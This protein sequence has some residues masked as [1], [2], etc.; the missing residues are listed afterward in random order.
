MKQYLANF[1]ELNLLGAN[2]VSEYLSGTKTNSQIAMDVKNLFIYAYNQGIRSTF[3]DLDEVDMAMYDDYVT[4]L[5]EKANKEVYKR[6]DGKDFDSKIKGYLQDG[7]ADGIQKVIETN[8]H[9]LFNAGGY[10][11]AKKYSSDNSKTIKKQWNTMEDDKVRDTHDYLDKMTTGIDDEFYTFNG[12]HSLYPGMFG[13][14]EEDINCRCF[15]TYS[16]QD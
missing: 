16:M 13:V 15:L 11:S 1:D 5:N 14:P 9:R 4:S 6:F 8:Y 7:N 2:F 10:D 3:E 12:N